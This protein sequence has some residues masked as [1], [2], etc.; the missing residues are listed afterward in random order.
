[1]IPYGHLTLITNVDRPGVIGRIA[2]VLGENNIN[3]AQ[4]QVGQEKDGEK[5][6]VFLRTDIPIPEEVLEKLSAL[7]M[8]NSVTHF[9]L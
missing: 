1:M 8:V 5:N 9:E 2:S 7:Q 6:V 4:M 3:I